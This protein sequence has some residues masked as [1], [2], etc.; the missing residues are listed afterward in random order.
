MQDGVHG[1]K[2]GCWG[3]CFTEVSSPHLSESFC[4]QSRFIADRLS[5]FIMF[6]ITY[7]LS[8]Q[9]RMVGGHIGSRD[10]LVHFHVPQ[11]V[12]FHLSTFHPFFTVHRCNGFMP[13]WSVQVLNVNAESSYKGIYL[14]SDR[15]ADR[16]AVML[17]GGGIDLKDSDDWTDRDGSLEAGLT[18]SP[19]AS[20]AEERCWMAACFQLKMVREETLCHQPHHIRATGSVL[21]CHPHHAALC[22]H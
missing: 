12:Q 5:I 17:A 19:T 14:L 2:L 10:K 6:Q 18:T 16:A 3:S 21:G 8:A 11:T 9:H 7:E 4:H 1:L 13:L 22:P 15:A 20:T